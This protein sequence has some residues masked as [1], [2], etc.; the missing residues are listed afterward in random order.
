[1]ADT[2]YT[3]GTTIASTW[4]NDVNNHVY[5]G[6]RLDTISVVNVKDPTFGAVGNGVADDTA[7]LQA[8]LNYVSSLGGGEV[9]VPHGQYRL[10]SRLTIPSRVLLKGS[11]WLPDPSNLQQTL[12]TSLFVDF[13]AG[14]APGSGN[15]AVQ[16]SYNSG[17]EGFTFYYPGQVAKT[18]ATPVVF[19]Y[20]ISTPT[21]GSSYDNI[22]LRN[23]TFYNSYAGANLSNGG[24][25][26]AVDLQGDPL[27]IGI[28]ADNC[29]DVCYLS[30]CHFWNFYTQAAALETWVAANGTAYDFDRI[31][32]LFAENLFGWNYNICYDLGA[33]FWGS[34]N[35]IL[36]DKANTPMKLTNVSQVNVS[37]FVFIGNP[38]VKPLIWHVS[39]TNGT[40]FSNGTLTS[41]GSVGAQIDG[42]D[43][44]TFSNVSF[45]NQHAASVTTNTT[46]NVHHTNCTW[47][48]P[49]MG[50]YN[51]RVNGERLPNRN[52][53]VTLPAPVTVPTVIGGG[54]QFDLST[55]GAKALQYD[56]TAISQRNSLYFLEFDYE[57][58]G[59]STTH[60]FQFNVQT[61][62]GSFTQVSYQPTFPMI[63]NG[64]PKK[65]RIPFFINHGRTQQLMTVIVTPTT[66]VPGA[67]IKMTN[68]VLY[69]QDNIYTTD[70][71]VSNMM[72]SGYNLDAYGK[73]QTLFTAGKGRIVITQP[74]AGIGRTTAVPTSGTWAV[75]DICRDD[76]PVA[77]GQYGYICTTAGTPGTW[78]SFGAIS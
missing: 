66:A 14:M 47:S 39:G 43:T 67:A 5:K 52:T 12:L 6:K 60:Y 41:A 56:V 36:C 75:G 77:G 7:A 68:I 69:E 22:S 20:S 15:H 62:V 17:I 37:N 24:R 51:V 9:F 11:E 3:A 49:P 57:L 27:F 63:L 13:G 76:T 71:Q 31:D 45:N 48:V 74:E 59:T 58:V 29:F 21:A 25:W 65:V 4:L 35:N 55:L 78:R 46:T 32:Q 8:A 2:L 70:A 28:K 19:D 1:M 64:T 53:A 26:R 34:F 38:S 23:I 16:M 30:R 40:H 42:G 61:S 10:T 33:S 72:R 54:Y 44:V 18:A 50:T 73:G